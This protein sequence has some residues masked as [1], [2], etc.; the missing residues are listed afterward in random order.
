MTVLVAALVND[1]V[2]VWGDEPT[3]DLDSTNAE[4]IMDLLCD[5]NEKNSQ[6]FVLVTHDRE[7]AARTHRIVYMTD[8]RIVDEKLTDRA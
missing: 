6:T 2:I 7:I 5:L 4:E 3:G 8:G 1:P